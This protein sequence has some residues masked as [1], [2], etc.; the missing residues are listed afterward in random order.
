ML[1]A[2][3]N[4]KVTKNLE[5]VESGEITFFITFFVNKQNFEPSMHHYLDLTQNQCEV[6]VFVHCIL[7]SELGCRGIC[8]SIAY[9]EVSRLLVCRIP[10]KKKYTDALAQKEK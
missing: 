7:A 1:Q 2:Q 9:H 5:A 8:K 10:N 4:F 6:E 3:R